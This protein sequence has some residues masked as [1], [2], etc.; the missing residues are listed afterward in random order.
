M[1]GAPRSD[2]AP[3]PTPAPAPAAP[4]PPALA[5]SRGYRSGS[6]GNTLQQTDQLTSAVLRRLALHARHWWAGGRRRAGWRQEAAAD[7]SATELLLQ[8]GAG[9]GT[10]AVDCRNHHEH[11]YIISEQQQD[12]G[13]LL[14]IK[15]CQLG[16]CEANLRALKCAGWSHASALKLMLT[17]FEVLHCTTKSL[18]DLPRRRPKTQ[19]FTAY[20]CCSKEYRRGPHA[21]RSLVV[22]GA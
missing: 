8:T 17:Q 9:T 12:V 6:R 22:P 1:A 2:S 5:A 21:P 11:C 15:D 4:A 3:A 16:R 7:R 14:A 13:M 20:S 18:Q 19:R 10:A